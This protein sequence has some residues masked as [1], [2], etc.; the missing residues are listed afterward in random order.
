VQKQFARFFVIKKNSSQEFNMGKKCSLTICLGMIFFL[1]TSVLSAAASVSGRV[2]D[3]FGQPLAG[4]QV[5][6]REEGSRVLTGRDG[7]FT[8][9]FADSRE[10]VELV[11]SS[12]LHHPES[13]QVEKADF[14]SP[15]EIF[16]TP[17][18][19]AREE[20]TITAPR[21]RVPLA[22]TPA[23]ASIVTRESLG[24]M[25]RAVAADEALK[26]VPGVKVD[27]QANG[28]RVHL[29]MRGIGILTERGIRGIQ[30]LV[31]GIPLNDPSGFAPDLFD[32][33]WSTVDHV[34]VIRGPLAFLYGG[35]S[36]GGVI[37]VVTREGA[38]V[39]AAGNAWVAAGSNAFWKSMAEAGGTAGK[40]D[41]LS[42]RVSLSRGTGD[43]YRD[44]TAFWSNNLYGKFRWHF[45]EN[46]QLS[47][48]VSGTGF[49][50][51]NAE[52][53]NLAWLA[54]DRRQA[55]PDAI[56]YNEFQKTRRVTTGVS[57]EWAISGSSG[58]SFT[59]FGRSTL[60]L[61]S[62]PSSL[63]HR[64][65]FQPGLLLQYRLVSGR[66]HFSAG[67]DWGRQSI[68][69]YR[70]PNLGEAREGDLL[71]SD[72]KMR[73]NG[74][75]VYVMDRLEMDPRISFTLGVRHDRVGNELTDRLKANG[76]DL[77]GTADFQ[78]TTARLGIN[79]NPGKRW[80]LYAGWGMGFLPPATEELYANP[81]ALGG[82]NRNLKPAT[83]SGGEIGVRG[84]LGRRFL[85]DLALFHLATHD[86]FERYRIP[87]RPLET[88]YGNA[89]NS[90]RNGLEASCSWLP[91][92]RLTLIAAYTYSDFTYS[93]YD[94]RTFPGNLS[95]HALPN[96]PR[97]QF[98]VDASYR[99][100][101]GWF[102]GFSAEGTSRASIDP[103]NAAWID[104]YVLCHGRVGFHWSGRL[105]GEVMLTVKNLADVKYIA[106]TEP[107]PDGNSYQPGAPREVFATVQFRF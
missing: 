38:D 63:Q 40:D 107:D 74:L 56:T 59:L 10:V 54:Q 106:F 49:F 60:W 53:L 6:V 82:F 36:S 1:A 72:Q 33:D 50:N 46:F 97:H 7:R 66:N 96:S 101:T 45:S 64:R 86:D 89:G 26:S 32:I 8:I 57:G 28:E 2:S 48:I 95:G 68:A 25:P 47:G 88:F 91:A 79:W 43:G 23:A 65:L 73:Q 99:F 81:E 103:T 61:E 104:G 17:L 105:Q 29:S 102:A 34:E 100:G 31:D 35:G 94:S 44:H 39:P 41:A 13:R 75:G 92:D 16:L 58:L 22:A 27:N 83:S 51:E 67:V 71:V 90:R 93:E 37:Q 69:E 77:S 98:F 3:I 42:Y 4:I 78:R 11:F 24:S 70:R 20:V 18:P 84:T 76:L 85:C 30:V 12:I 87:G 19:M 15:L 5:L 80:S 62:V 21:Q 14:A 55:N 52:G 9:R